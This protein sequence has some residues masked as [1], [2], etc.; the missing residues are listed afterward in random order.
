MALLLQNTNP[1]DGNEVQNYIKV[2]EVCTSIINKD[3]SYVNY[4]VYLNK[5]ARDNWLAPID[6]GNIKLTAEQF[7]QFFWLSVLEASWVNS[8]KQAYELLKSLEQFSD[9]VDC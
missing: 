8:F 4:V 3:T 2:T 7:D 1:Y 5:Y 6:A 9:A